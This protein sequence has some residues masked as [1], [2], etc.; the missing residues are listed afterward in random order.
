MIT[1]DSSAET[2]HGQ[3]FNDYGLVQD[4]YLKNLTLTDDLERTYLQDI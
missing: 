4:R 1:L 2:G 3:G